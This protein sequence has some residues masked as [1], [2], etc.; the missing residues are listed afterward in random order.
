MVFMTRFSH[1]ENIRRISWYLLSSFDLLYVTA[2]ATLSG[3]TEDAAGSRYL[4]DSPDNILLGAIWP[5]T[6][7]LIGF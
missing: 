4:L 7:L 5:S 1:L 6:D 3:Y 2:H